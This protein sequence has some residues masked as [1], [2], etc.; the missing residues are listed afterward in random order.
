MVNLM[1]LLRQGRTHHPSI[2]CVE[3]RGVD[4]VEGLG[5]ES[6]WS[7][8]GAL[9][10]RGTEDG[11]D[12]EGTGGPLLGGRSFGLAWAGGPRGVSGWNA[13]LVNFVLSGD[14]THGQSGAA[15]GQL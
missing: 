11:G 5:D 1:V 3:E 13:R 7:R 9:G 8:R 6:Q 4:G 15:G 10:S 12:G 2:S 14:R